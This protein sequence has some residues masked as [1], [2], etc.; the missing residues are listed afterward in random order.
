LK[1]FDSR[2]VLIGASTGALVMLS[3]AL[4]GPD[5]I[6]GKAAGQQRNSKAEWGRHFDGGVKKD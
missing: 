4:F 6:P 5:K 3:L 1:V 2:R